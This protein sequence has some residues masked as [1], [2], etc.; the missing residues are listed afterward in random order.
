MYVCTLSTVKGHRDGKNTILT[1]KEF[2]ILRG[3]VS[4]NCLFHINYQNKTKNEGRSWGLLLAF[5]MV[6]AFEEAGF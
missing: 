1:L 4:K 3:I 6:G 2:T 5:I